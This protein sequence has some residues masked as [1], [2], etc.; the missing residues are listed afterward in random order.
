M[1]P[2]NKKKLEK[3]RKKLDLLDNKLLDIIKKRTA[4]INNVLKLKKYKK[5]IIDKNRIR[6]ILK[7]I[8]IKSKRKKIDT[9]V[10]NKIWKEMISAY[11]DYEFR[12]FRKK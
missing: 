12:K 11:I 7:D 10:T 3:L 1:S 6:N 2:E 4:I 5:E 9:K 8:K